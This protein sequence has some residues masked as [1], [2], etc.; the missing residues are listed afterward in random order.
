MLILLLLLLLIISL[1][2]SI[3]QVE[4]DI[5]HYIG[6]STESTAQNS[7]NAYVSLIH[8]VDSSYRYRG[9]L[10]NALITKKI[11]KELGS[12]ADFI[13]LV[14]YSSYKEEENKHL[15]EDDIKLLELSGIRVYFLPRIIRYPAKTKVSF[16][17]M[18]L[19]KVLPFSFTIYDRL[20]FLDGDVMP[21]KNMDCFFQLNINSYNTGSASPVNSGWYLIIPN[22]QHYNELMKLA[23][24]RLETKWNE[25]IG[26][27]TIIPQS[28]KYRGGDKSVRSWHFNGASL[29][30]GLVT[31]FFV[32]NTGEIQIIDTNDTKIYS[33]NYKFTK[34]T[35]SKELK[36]CNGIISTSFFAH[37]TGRNKPWLA[38]SIRKPNSLVKTWLKHLDSLKLKINSSNI[39]TFANYNS[40]LGYFFP[41]K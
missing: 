25:T 26:W 17:E 27:G 18:A 31:H 34:S 6:F 14:G 1:S 5:D 35:F 15:F 29:D 2:R 10:Y 30:Q 28:L 7:K 23:G 40:P 9:F 32:L 38:E 20:Q 12:T 24:W 33:S 22:M 37:F 21:H 8:G 3:L 36:C 39:A 13:V 16:A 4:S 19:L 41:N 11:F